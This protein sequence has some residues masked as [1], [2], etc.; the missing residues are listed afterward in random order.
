MEGGLRLACT[1]DKVGHITL[2]VSLYSRS[3]AGWETHVDVPL[4]A[5]QLDR[6]AGEVRRLLAI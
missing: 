2:R 6:V 1:H 4:E 3:G 5:G